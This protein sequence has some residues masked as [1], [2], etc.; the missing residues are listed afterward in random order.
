MGSLPGS[1]IKSE[2]GRELAGGIIGRAEPYPSSLSSSLHPHHFHFP[3]YE[4]FIS[5][6]KLIEYILLLLPMQAGAN[7]LLMSTIGVE[8]VTAQVPTNWFVVVQC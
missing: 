5:Q 7:N 1:E 2:A 8:L 3:V 4:E 6:E